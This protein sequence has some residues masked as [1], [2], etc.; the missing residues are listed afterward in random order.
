LWDLLFA[1]VDHADKNGNR[2]PVDYRMR[3]ASEIDKTFRD[4]AAWP[5]MHAS[6]DG[7]RDFYFVPRAGFTIAPSLP[8]PEVGYCVRWTGAFW[9]P[10]TKVKD[11]IAAGYLPLKMRW[12][13]PLPKAGDFLCSGPRARCVYAIR[14]VERL[15]PHLNSQRWTCRLWCDRI[16]PEDLP[17]DAR[18]HSF[19]WDPRGK[20]KR[21]R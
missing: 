6:R 15:D 5:V 9:A 11:R 18:V 20:R 10:V 4:G 2:K 3:V 21:R 8:R 7:S 19:W 13:K 1:F 17:S 14:M 16:L 12:P